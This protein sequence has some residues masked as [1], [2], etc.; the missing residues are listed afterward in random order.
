MGIYIG[1]RDSDIKLWAYAYFSSN[2]FPE[3]DKDDSDTE[4]YRSTFIVS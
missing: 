4:N 2:W 1:P 3:E